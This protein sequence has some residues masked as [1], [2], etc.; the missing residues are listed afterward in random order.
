MDITLYIPYNKPPHNIPFNRIEDLETFCYKY[1]SKGIFQNNKYIFHIDKP[2]IGKF[3]FLIINNR[4]KN[5]PY[6]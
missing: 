3:F 1:Q 6:A 4:Q 5:G 2:H